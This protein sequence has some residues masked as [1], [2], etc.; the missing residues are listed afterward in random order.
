MINLETEWIREQ[1]RNVEKRVSL[2]AT[3]LDWADGKQVLE[4]TELAPK[5]N[6]P[7]RKVWDRLTQ[8]VQSMGP[9]IIKH[10]VTSAIGSVN[11]GG[12]NPGDIDSRL[13]EI[14]LEM[15]AR[16]SLKSLCAVGI[17]GVWA[18]QPEFGQPR[19][20]RL[21]GYLEP[22]YHEDDAGG[23]PV[24]WF[25]A[26]S[27]ANGK[28]YRLRIYEPYP[29]NPRYGTIWEWRN[30]RSP[31]TI[32]NRPTNEFPDQMMPRFAILDRDQAG[33]PIGELQTALP[34]LKAEVAQQLRELRASDANASPLK[35]MKG[36]WD[37]PA[38]GV[39]PETLLVAN[40][41]EAEMGRL[42]PPTLE[43]LF[44]MHDRL[45]E[46]I[47]G[48]LQLPISSI[49][50]GTFPSGEALDQANATAVA[51]A[52]TYASLI[53]KLL[54]DGVRDLAELIGLDPE[55]APRVSVTINREPLRRIISEQARNDYAAGLIPFRAAA[56]ALQPYYP[57]MSDAE[58]EEWI[59]GQERRVS[60]NDFNALVSGGE[61]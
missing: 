13:E 53:S 32:G 57:H 38:E 34:L 12:K 36:D 28:Q 10:K 46:R 25:Q 40:S 41:M 31:S 54:S 5:V 15:M 60:V 39:G 6:E 48:D 8:Q 33:L 7:A 20:Q 42:E 58:L 29:D 9:R 59:S 47:R 17:A 35:W 45:Y 52:T 19:L 21:G 43:G 2:A 44:S 24:A 49:T 3:L 30:Q 11:W 14:D 37:V 16:D 50:T 56:L 27:E 51:N 22:L 18:Y 26:L 1:L 23:T 4:E 55:E 61:E